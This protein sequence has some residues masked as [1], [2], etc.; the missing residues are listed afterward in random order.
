[1]NLLAL[2]MLHPASAQQ[3]YTPKLEVLEK[4]F[5][6]KIA[7]PKDW[8][9]TPIGVIHPPK[10]LFS[11]I[12]HPPSPARLKDKKAELVIN[13]FNNPS[14]S[15]HLTC[16]YYPEVWR[17][18]VNKSGGIFLGLQT[19]SKVEAD[20]ELVKSMVFW[21]E[22]QGLMGCWFGAAYLCE[23][24]VVEAGANVFSEKYLLQVRL[25]ID[26]QDYQKHALTLNQILDSIRIKVEGWQ[27]PVRK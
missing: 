8:I 24:N 4:E 16:F 18:E 17:E 25:L 1:M 26:R 23:D 3:I 13:V 10:M 12:W 14:Q 9:E 27:R 7:L 19:G 21:N 22:K 2:T 20:S 6:F 15:L 11:Y 5:G